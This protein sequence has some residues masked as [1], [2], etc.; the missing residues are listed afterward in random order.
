[1]PGFSPTFKIQGKVYHR[2]GSLLP[3]TGEPPK[4]AQMYVHYT[5]HELQNRLHHN[6]H[7]HPDILTALQTYLHRVNHCVCSFKS[8]KEFAA[9]H[10]ETKV[11]LNATKTKQPVNILVATTYLQALKLQ[12]SC[13]EKK[14]MIRMS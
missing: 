6:S 7:V 8:A 13:Q 12:S 14:H 10:P 4:F 2:F 5:E 3:R 11:V 1:M 9:N